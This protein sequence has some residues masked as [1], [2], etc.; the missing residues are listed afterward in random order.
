MIADDDSQSQP[1]MER[2]EVVAGPAATPVQGGVELS[3]VGTTVF[4]SVIM[5]IRNEARFIRRSLGALLGQDYPLGHMEILVADGHSTDGTR[6][7]VRGLQQRHPQLK[8]LDN[9]GRIV[10]T[11]MNEG[12]RRARGEVI[13]RVDG[14]TVVAPDYISCCV[15][16][17]QRSGADN[18]GGRMDAVGEGRFGEAV[19]LATCSPFGVGGARFH[20]S[21]R[22]EWVDTVYM[23]AWRRATFDRVGLFDETMV[24]NQDDELNYRLLERGGRILL[25]PSIR[26]TYTVRSAPGALWRQYFQYGLCRHW[27]Q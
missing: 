16:S 4:V 2:T 10:A 19:V 1:S 3:P 17:I 7:I 23:G 20:Y 11:G 18:T 14:H 25:D 26:S 6:D 22:E 21:Q 12:I 27:P 8:L 9:P 5:P 13:V 24:R 15:A